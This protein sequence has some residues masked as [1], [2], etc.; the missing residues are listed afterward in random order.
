MVIGIECHARPRTLLQGCDC[1]CV[2]RLGKV[3]RGRE[4]GARES[5]A[6]EAPA[7]PRLLFPAETERTT[8]AWLRKQQGSEVRAKLKTSAKAQQSLANQSRFCGLLL[9]LALA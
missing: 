2:V 6:Q 4:L 8:K 5:K 7:L 9:L 1:V 3:K